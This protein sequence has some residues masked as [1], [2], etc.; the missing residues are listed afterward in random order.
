MVEARALFE[1]LVAPARHDTGDRRGEPVG[2]R[3]TP[4]ERG[5]P[6]QSCAVHPA[7]REGELTEMT[8]TP[9]RSEDELRRPRGGE[10]PPGDQPSAL[11]DEAMRPA[12]GGRIPGTSGAPGAP[13]GP[14]AFGPAPGETAGSPG[15]GP[16]A[17]GDIPGT[18]GPL[19]GAGGLPLRAVRRRA[20][21]LRPLTPS[22]PA[23]IPPASR[24]RAASRKAP[25]PPPSSPSAP[26]PPGTAAPLGCQCAR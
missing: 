2:H 4:A 8:D 13:G 11:G 14:G 19:P 17:A 16:G 15:P 26:S 3:A 5:R 20:T 12:E 7:P 9:R 6:H 21:R 22:T 1:D 23:R 24:P 18:V 10:I 25:A